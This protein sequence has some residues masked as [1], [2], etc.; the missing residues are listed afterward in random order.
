MKFEIKNRWSLKVQFECE[1]DAKFDSESYGVQ[2]GAAIKAAYKTRADLT[3]TVLTDADLTR[4]VL[5]RTDLTDAVLTGIVLTG[6]DLTDADLTRADL[7]RAD[8]TDADL[9][10]AVLTGAVLTGAVLTGTILTR[11]VLTP[12][13]VDLFDVLLRAP[14]EVSGLIQALRDGKVDG[15]IYEGDCACLV[16]TIANLQHCKYNEV[17]NLNINSNR[18]AERWFLGIRRGDTPDNSNLVKITIEWI[19]EFQLLAAAMQTADSRSDK[20]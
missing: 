19:E 10:D 16:G 3:G 18:P 13:R 6:A 9:T 14:H 17:P 8:L 2:L 20:S 15:G 5:T 1:L 7:T 11:A 12:I 4:A